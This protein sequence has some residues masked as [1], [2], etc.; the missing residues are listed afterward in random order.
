MLSLAI[1]GLA[2]AEFSPDDYT[3]NI[4]SFGTDGAT[5]NPYP[6]ENS[7]KDANSIYGALQVAANKETKKKEVG[8][9]VDED[10]L[11]LSCKE[12]GAGIHTVT[13][14][15]DLMVVT[16]QNT[17]GMDMYIGKLSFGGSVAEKIFNSLDPSLAIVRMG[18]TTISVGNLVCSKAVLPEPV[19][20]CSIDN[21]SVVQTSAG[22]M[23]KEGVM[24]ADE[25]KQLVEISGLD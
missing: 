16:K 1:S 17:P 21:A 2:Q 18:G 19:F 6:H 5:L 20:T 15:C 13:G 4:V 10:I 3:F 24:T 25:V 12:P 11:G 23:V 7:V 8:T 9:V 14:G 22:F